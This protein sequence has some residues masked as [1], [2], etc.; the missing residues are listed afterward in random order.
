MNKNIFSITAA[1]IAAL[2]VA[3]FSAH[4]APLPICDK[5]EPHFPC[6]QHDN[7]KSSGTNGKVIEA[8]KVLEC[9][10]RKTGVYCA[11]ADGS[12]IR[13]YIPPNCGDGEEASARTQSCEAWFNPKWRKLFES[14]R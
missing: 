7:S 12:I 9:D 2:M 6:L 14:R 11:F 13:Q 10:I 4:A 8:P 1:A 3:I 5:F